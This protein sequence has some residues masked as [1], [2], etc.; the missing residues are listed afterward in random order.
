MTLPASPLEESAW[1]EAAHATVAAALGLEV[2][3]VDVTGDGGI[4]RTACRDDPLARAIVASIPGA[5]G[6]DQAAARAACAALGIDEAVAQLLAGA[7]VDQYATFIGALGS[8]L[9]R[10]GY[11][12]GDDLRTW[13]ESQR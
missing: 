5:S 10:A 11:L 9:H 12:D 8:E 4:T 2:F 13:W 3:S 1:H 7:L 6:P